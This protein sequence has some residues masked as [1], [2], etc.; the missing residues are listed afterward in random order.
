MMSVP[1]SMSR[2]RPPEPAAAA[3][4][5]DAFRSRHPAGILAQPATPG[6][7]ACRP[8]A[9]ES[10]K[11]IGR[12]GDAPT[13]RSSAIPSSDGRR[14]ISSSWDPL[15]LDRLAFDQLSLH[16]LFLSQLQQPRATPIMAKRVSLD[17]SLRPW[18]SEYC[19]YLPKWLARNAY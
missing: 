11:P 3:C 2:P 17:Y 15:P 4:P 19:W 5:R 13:P 10:S 9:E 6:R 8:A 14:Q 1:E 12:D 18:V 16:Q 7:K